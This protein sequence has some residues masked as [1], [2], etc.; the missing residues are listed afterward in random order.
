MLQKDC[1]RAS[2]L[3]RP[4]REVRVVCAGKATPVWPGSAGP[5]AFT[6]AN[7]RTALSPLP[8]S[9]SSLC[10]LRSYP[11]V[12]LHS[13]ELTLGRP[14]ADQS[15][16]ASSR[17]LTAALDSFT[18]GDFSL[19]SF[20]RTGPPCTRPFARLTATLAPLPP[21]A[22]LRTQ[23][24]P[25]PLSTPLLRLHPHLRSSPCLP[26]RNPRRRRPSACTSSQE[27]V[28]AWPKPSA[29]TGS[30]RSRRVSPAPPPPLSL[31][32]SLPSAALTRFSPVRL[33]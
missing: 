29:V 11:C 31:S 22:S 25:L 7:L 27:V 6:R 19:V 26:A 4:E 1:Q 15:R 32:L 12:S 21:T 20:V 17:R 14:G 30:T 10:S 13:S 2:V 3:A 5:I 24:L 16:L 9:S 23:R 33:M 8:A 18:A 28:Q